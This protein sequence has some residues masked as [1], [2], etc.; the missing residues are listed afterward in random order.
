MGEGK[1][2][3]ILIFAMIAGVIFL[4]LRSVLGRRTGQ[5][6]PPRDLVSRRGAEASTAA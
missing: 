6:K 2:L 3:D 1:L 4:R 5:E